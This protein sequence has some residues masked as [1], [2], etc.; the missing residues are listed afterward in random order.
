MN[1]CL[2][3]INT[4]VVNHF[5]AIPSGLIQR[6]VPF[7]GGVG[8]VAIDASNVYKSSYGKCYIIVC[9]F[10]ANTSNGRFYDHKAVSLHFND[11]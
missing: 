6:C 1:K 5:L 4:Y 7:G 11:H 10:T 3:N 9:E 8:G 2:L